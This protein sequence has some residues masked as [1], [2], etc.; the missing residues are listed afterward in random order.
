MDPRVG[1]F[2]LVTVAELLFEETVFVV[3]A[4]ADRGEIE[5][6]QGIEE[7]G[8]EAPET[9]VAECHVVFLVARFL[10]GMPQILQRFGHFF[11]HTG[12][13]HVVDEQA[14]HEEFHRE[15]VNAAHVAFVVHG[16]GFH[17][18]RD[19]DALDG[20]RGGDPPLAARGGDGITRERELQ[21]VDDLFL[22]G[23][24]RGLFHG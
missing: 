7:A 8:G 18:P 21:L 15:I 13:D 11:E 19:D 17:H 24:G 23:N 20:H 22:K 14:P 6:G 3:D 1:K 10:E 4:V 16:K 5:S 9:A 12:R 2:D